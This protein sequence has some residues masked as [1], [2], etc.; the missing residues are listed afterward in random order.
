MR[1]RQYVRRDL[2]RA[3]YTTVILVG[4]KGALTYGV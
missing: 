3:G 2:E 1:E 4:R